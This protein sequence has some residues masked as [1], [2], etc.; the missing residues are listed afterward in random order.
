MTTEFLCDIL[1]R[2][3][4]ITDFLYK[5]SHDKCSQSLDTTVKIYLKTSAEYYYSDK[6]F[7]RQSWWN[8]TE[9][10]SYKLRF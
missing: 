10:E 4:E 3:N 9:D 7:S 2:C 8:L 1:Q 6:S 5:N